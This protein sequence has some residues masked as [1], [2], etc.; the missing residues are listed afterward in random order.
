MRG[1][2]V[3]GD[4]EVAHGPRLVG[5]QAQITA[6]FPAAYEPEAALAVGVVEAPGI[7]LVELA[8]KNPDCAG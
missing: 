5:T 7:G 4:P 8:C 6:W 3:M 2:Q 1:G